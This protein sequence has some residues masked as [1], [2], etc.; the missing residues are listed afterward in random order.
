M[1]YRIAFGLIVLASIIPRPGSAQEITGW[2][3]VAYTTGMGQANREG[4]FVFPDY[5]VIESIEPNSPAQRAGLEAGDTIL[6][7]NAQDMRKAPLPMAEWIQPDKKVLFRYKR[8]GVVRETTVRVARRAQ[9]RPPPDVVISI[10]GPNGTGE[11]VA[12]TPRRD[13]AVTERDLRA[14]VPVPLLS[15]TWDVLPVF[16]ARLTAMKEG[17]RALAGT[18]S[19]NGLF[20][21]TVSAGSP[22][23]QSGLREGDVILRAAR[24]Q[25]GDPADL[26]KLVSEANGQLQLQIYRNKKPQTVVL[27]W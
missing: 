2:V 25:L 6:A 11:R 20:V 17:L 16:G 26:M 8:N 12:P 19:R 13:R 9:D 24:M 5:P 7:M 21:V 23:S 15:P 27:K 3:G 22:A 1:K 10:Y 4:V 14:G 18:N